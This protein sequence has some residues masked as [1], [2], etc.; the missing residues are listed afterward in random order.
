MKNSS[1]VKDIFIFDVAN[2]P[3]G[4]Y[5]ISIISGNSAQTRKLQV[6]K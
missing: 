1:T 2:Y 6:I 3:D 4:I 5:L